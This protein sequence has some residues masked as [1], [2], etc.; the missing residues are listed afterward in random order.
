LAGGESDRR[1]VELNVLAQMQALANVPEVAS[2]MGSR[3]LKIHGLVY[4]R[5]KNKIIRLET[6]S[7]R[8]AQ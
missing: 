2:A 8:P 6:E 5:S 1:F 4:D 7:E 3:G